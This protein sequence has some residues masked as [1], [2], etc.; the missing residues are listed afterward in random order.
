M[1][2]EVIDLARALILDD[3]DQPLCIAARSFQV[4]LMDIL[5]GITEDENSDEEEASA[6]GSDATT[7]RGADS[8]M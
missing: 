8:I 7:S 5:D 2:H 4:A 1:R 6:G 3:G